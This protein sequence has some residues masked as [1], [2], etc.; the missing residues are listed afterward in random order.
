MKLLI[1]LI[2]LVSCQYQKEDLK[3]IGL[4]SVC[5]EE[6]SSVTSEN[7]T[8]LEV[9]LAGF[10]RRYVKV[11]DCNFDTRMDYQSL[12]E[13]KNSEPEVYKKQREEI[14]ALL[15]NEDL[16]NKSDDFKKAFLINAY[17]FIAIDI[18][19]ENSNA[20]LIKSIA[21]LG[22]TNSFNAF[23]DDENF[24]YDVAGKWL[25]LDGI[26][27]EELAEITGGAD[28]RIH[29][30]VICASAGCPVLLDV[31]FNEKD[32][33]HQLDFVTQAGLRLP[34]MFSP[35]IGKVSLSG[36]FQWYEQD[37]INDASRDKSCGDDKKCL[38]TFLQRYLDKDVAADTSKIE[39]IKY[40]WNLNKV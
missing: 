8:K 2:F 17:N 32:L 1:F 6:K 16:T 24:G 38:R 25:S 15:A 23:W 12:L 3:Q 34:R 9:K 37:F 10:Y 35:G 21:N 28:A 30:A 22:G 13:L 5:H 27:K 36:I 29:F 40:D 14:L 4:S 26:E 20:N 18:V 33:E 19:V 39:Y 7:L 31:P 11:L